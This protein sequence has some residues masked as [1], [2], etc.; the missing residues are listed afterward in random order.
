MTHDADDSRD[1]EV[2]QILRRATAGDAAAMEQLF[3]VVY[4]DLRRIAQRRISGE[5]VD[6]TLQAT[7]L[8]HEAYL[9]LIDQR[10]A[11]YQNR[12]HF[13]KIAARAMRRILV[14]HARAKGRRKR[15]GD[16]EREELDERLP[17]GE[18][19]VETPQLNLIRLDQALSELARAHPEE[20]QVAEL[21]F[22]AGLS[23]EET[24]EALGVSP[25]TVRRYWREARNRLYRALGE[26]APPDSL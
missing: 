24:A 5:R 6:H 11:G 1:L 21:R 23:E 2:T 13:F 14:D 9:R 20:A 18:S 19:D 12:A 10:E 25:R 8:V 15:G 16:Q 17:A 3:T 7:A 4:Q 26:G 22:F